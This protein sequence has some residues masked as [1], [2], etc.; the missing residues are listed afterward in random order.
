MLITCPNC[1]ASYEVKSDALAPGGRAVRCADAARCGRR[2]R[3]SPLRAA[4]ALIG[5]TGGAGLARASKH[6]RGR[7]RTGRSR[8]AADWSAPDDAGSRRSLPR[9]RST[10]PRRSFPS[11]K[12]PIIDQVPASLHPESGAS[13]DVES[14]AARRIRRV[15]ARR[16]KR[17]R[18]PGLPLLI[19]GL[20][21][22]LTS[23]WPSG[24]T[25]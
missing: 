23:L 20:I 17:R 12:A 19:L 18:A 2:K 1:A 5:P 6:R 22:V 16:R 3:P 25:R 9:R 8:V 10:T 7:A 24:A 13:E 4:L 15:R 21:A 11:S 14:L